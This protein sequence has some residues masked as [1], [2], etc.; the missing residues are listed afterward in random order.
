MQNAKLNSSATIGKAWGGSF[1]GQDPYTTRC[2]ERVFVGCQNNIVFHKDPDQQGTPPA[3]KM[4]A[5]LCRF[6]KQR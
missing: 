6:A 3:S 2:F 4:H 5:L 1:G